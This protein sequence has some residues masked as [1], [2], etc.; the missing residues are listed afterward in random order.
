MLQ[1]L[2]PLEPSTLSDKTLQKKQMNPD[3]ISSSFYIA[4]LCSMIHE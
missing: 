3:T 2:P 4:Y 1:I